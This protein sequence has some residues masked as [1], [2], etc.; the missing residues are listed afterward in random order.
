MSYALF[1]YDTPNSL[2]TLTERARPPTEAR[3]GGTGRH[4]DEPQR[5]AK[6]DAGTG[7]RARRSVQVEDHSAHYGD[8]DEP[9]GKM[10][11]EAESLLADRDNLWLQ[12][13]RALAAIRSSTSPNFS[14]GT[15]SDSCRTGSTPRPSPSAISHS[16]STTRGVSSMP[17]A[18]THRMARW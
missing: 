8:H 9:S 4:N 16:G 13:R 10:G 12:R 15:G 1:D 14:A 5:L 11:P 3:H 2:E 6:R 18:L 7:S 17:L